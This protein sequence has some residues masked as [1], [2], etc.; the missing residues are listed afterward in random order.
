[1]YL[2]NGKIDISLTNQGYLAP[3]VPGT[4][5]GLAL[6]HKKLRDLPWKDVVM[7]AVALAENGFTMSDGARAQSQQPALRRDGTFPGVGGRLRKAR[8]RPVGAR[9]SPGAE[10]LAKTLRAIATEGPDV[11]YKGWIA[12]RIAEDMAANGGLI[13]KEDLAQYQAKERAPV[14]GQLRTA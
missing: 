3:G 7:P 11:F 12:D 9:R 1:M 10:D 2:R 8:S 13:T 4:V 6:A 5:R 14:R